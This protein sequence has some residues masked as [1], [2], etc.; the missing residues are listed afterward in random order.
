MFCTM[1][2]CGRAA[3]L[4]RGPHDIDGGPERRVGAAETR[5]LEQPVDAG[6]SHIQPRCFRRLTQCLSFRR[7]L[8][9]RGCERAGPLDE[10]IRRPGALHDWRFFGAECGLRVQ[11]YLHGS[12]FL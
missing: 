8:T 12:E 5:R 3:G 9:Q 11:G 6:A 1:A 7:A 4:P 2:Q 10:V